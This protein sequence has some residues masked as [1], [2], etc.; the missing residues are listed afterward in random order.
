M[1]SSYVINLTFLFLLNVSF[2]VAGIF[3]NSVVIISLRRSSQL[4]KKICY[5]MILVLSCFDLAA[6]AI[7]H[8]L[9][10]LSTMVW[11]LRPSREIYHIRILTTIHLAGFSMFALLTLN[12][13]RFL[14]LTFPFF[15]QS[16]VTKRRI[17]T[18]LAIWMIIQITL[19]PLFY[20]Y[21]T[22]LT[23][24]LIIGFISILLC[25]FNYLNYK[26]LF[27]AKSKRKAERIATN[28]KKERKKRKINF[29][30]ISTC[31][32]AVGC[33]SIFCLPQLIFSLWSTIL[34]KP[35]DDVEVFVYGIW[36]STFILMN[37]T[38]NC[39]TF[40]WKNSI[41]RRE[42]MKTAKSFWTK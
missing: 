20:F 4:R 22:P 1:D 17:T 24:A 28:S 29:K 25:A 8:P 23:N 2:M 36:S 26:V 12:I 30:D 11:A 40:F 33:F 5:F 38:F 15:H 16:V 34:N 10:V 6:V 3:L 41:L 13:E 7:V 37:S 39:L 27:I 19:S 42:G 18:F 21:D 35:R 14:A 32:L 31:W 9:L